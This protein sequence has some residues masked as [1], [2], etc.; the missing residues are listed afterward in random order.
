MR[1]PIYAIEKEQGYAVL[2][3][4]LEFVL[5]EENEEIKV[6]FSSLLNEGYANIILDLGKTTY[7]S[8]LVIASF[9]F[10]HKTL[11]DAGGHL[12]FCQLNNKVKELLSI[13]N[14]DRV[15]EIASDRNEAVARILGKDR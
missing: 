1:D 7:I 15:F 2:C 9:V 8:S 11:K 6:A 10:M 13:T 3:L 12:I 5:A 14:L 4:I